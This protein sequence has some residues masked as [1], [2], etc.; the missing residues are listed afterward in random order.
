M[1]C[2]LEVLVMIR[3]LQV[4][5]DQTVVHPW[6]VELKSGNNL[7]IKCYKTKVNG[8][9]YII[10]LQLIHPSFNYDVNSIQL[11]VLSYIHAS[12]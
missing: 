3:P 8:H 2:H 11:A 9:M 1:I 12:Y 5:Q 4:S 7:K 10:N 6:H